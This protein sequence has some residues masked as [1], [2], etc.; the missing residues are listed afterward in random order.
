MAFSRGNDTDIRPGIFEVPL[1][2]TV[3]AKM[4]KKNGESKVDEKN[5]MV[6][7]N[8]KIT[9]KAIEVVVAFPRQD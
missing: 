1:L 6:S 5:E 8:W 7:R 9:W 4:K 2:K 3:T